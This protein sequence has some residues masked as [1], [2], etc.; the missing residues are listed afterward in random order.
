MSE[1]YVTPSGSPIVQ[2][3][4]SKI[5][6]DGSITLIPSGKD[7]WYGKIQSFADS[8]DIN[9]ILKRCAVGD[10]SALNRVQGFY[11]DVTGMPKNNAELLQMVIDGQKNF[12]QLP[13]EIR[14]RFDNDF[15]KFFATMDQPE[16]FEKM[17]MIKKEDAAAV[18]DP[19]KEEVKE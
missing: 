9:T 10:D 13:L 15:N 2:Q 17:K 11:A 19:I 12:E 14:Q 3:F 18:S 6:D 5:E 7:D 4:D 16:W 8:V 1:I